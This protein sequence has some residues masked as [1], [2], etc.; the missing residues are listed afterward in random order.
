MEIDINNLIELAKTA[1]EA[2]LEIYRGD[3]SVVEKDDHSPL[4]EADTRSHRIIAGELKRRYPNI[5]LLSE[6]G[7]QI[8]YEQRCRW[9]RYWLI[10]PL[11]GTKE[12]IKRNGEFT[13]NIALIEGRTPVI[14]VVYIPVRDLLYVGEV[15]KG[16][17]QWSGNNKQLLKLDES[18][19]RSP[20]RV[21]CSRSH[22]SRTLE[23]FLRQLPPHQRIA[24][25]SSLKFC[26]LAAGDAEFYP[27]LGPTSEWD[28]AAG[29]AVVCA[30]GGVVVD[31]EGRPFLY[32]KPNL[33][34]GPFMVAPGIQWMK[35]HGVFE[36]LKTLKT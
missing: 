21:V 15:G 24:R 2:I 5:P 33:V 28:T 19:E 10:D 22:V 31:L 32:N 13:V 12:F 4:T 11:D 8:P 30:A 9:S 14:G 26:A 20:I 27:R 35:R 29:Q 16:C 25:G 23:E 7:K 17:W 3:F 36:A 18:V 6:E 34:N 1:G